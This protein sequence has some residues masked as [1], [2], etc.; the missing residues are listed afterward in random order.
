MLYLGI[1]LNTQACIWYSTTQIGKDD[2]HIHDGVSISQQ[3]Y[4]PTEWL[5]YPDNGWFKGTAVQKYFK[6]LY[7]SVLILGVNE[8]GP[9]SILETVVILLML[10]CSLFINANLFGELAV[11]IST[12]KHKKEQY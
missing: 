2:F 6:A 5:N 11:L 9:V 1:L 10:F 8:L 7:H 12:M 4:P 3:W